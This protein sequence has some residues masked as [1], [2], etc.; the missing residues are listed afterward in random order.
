MEQ[1]RPS[2]DTTP[3]SSKE[4]IGEVMLL[5]YDWTPGQT[6]IRFRFPEGALTADAAG[7][8]RRRQFGALVVSE[9]RI[10]MDQEA[11]T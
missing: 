7:D 9:L 10:A 6:E 5:V 2:T 8:A 1:P 4:P 3:E 11:T